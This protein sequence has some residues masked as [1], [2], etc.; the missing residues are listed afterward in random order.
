MRMRSGTV[1]KQKD[2]E[3]EKDVGTDLRGRKGHE[4]RKEDRER[5]D[6]I[7]LVPE[8]IEG[9]EVHIVSVEANRATARQRTNTDSVDGHE[10]N[11]YI[12]TATGN[13]KSTSSA[14]VEAVPEG[15][16]TDR[17]GSKHVH[18]DATVPGARDATGLS[19][20]ISQRKDPQPQD[21]DNRERPFGG[22]FGRNGNE[23]A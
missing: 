19:H 8:K 16:R 12:C 18:K 1:M 10:K 14:S 9:R 6:R 4:R 11:R 13:R 15:R 3:A 21:A 5:R 17:G 2:G 23:S 22:T 20:Y 7:T